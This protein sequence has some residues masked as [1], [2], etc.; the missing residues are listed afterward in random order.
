VYWVDEILNAS[1]RLKCLNERKK[2]IYI[3]TAEGCSRC[4][5]LKRRYDESGI[6]YKERSANRLSSPDDRRDQVDVD[7]FAQLCMQ[8]MILPVEINTGEGNV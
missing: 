1:K 3:Y 4:D 8:N 6:T 7:A 2:M 5:D